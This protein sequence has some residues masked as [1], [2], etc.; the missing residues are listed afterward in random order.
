MQMK[1]I[2]TFFWTCLL[3]FT[4]KAQ[5]PHPAIKQFLIEMKDD[6]I[7]N[8]LKEL[9]GEKTCIVKGQTTTIKNRVSKNGNDLAA[10][11]LKERLESYGLTVTDQKYS[12][13]GR[14]IFAEQKGDMY[15]DK[16]FLICA[17]YDSMADYCADDN[18]SGCSA[19]LE[20]VRVL[21][22]Y[23]FKHTIV[24][25]FWD[26]EEQGLIGSAYYAKQAKSSGMNIMGVLNMDMIGYDGNNDTKFE[27]YTKAGGSLSLSDKLQQ[28][29]TAY[30]FK[31]SPIVKNPGPTDT[32]HASF[33]T[34]GYSAIHF[35][36][37]FSAGD[38]NPAYHKSTDRISLFN[39]P[40]FYQLCRLGLSA[41]ATL[42]EPY[43]VTGIGTEE[44]ADNMKLQAYPNPAR[45][46]LTINY[47]LQETTDLQIRLCNALNSTAE[48]ILHETENAGTHQ[49]IINTDNLASGIYFIVMTGNSKIYT[50][51]IVIEK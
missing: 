25:A 11:Y 9:S 47:E 27:I 48:I 2:Y 29:N 14:N 17:H 38:A 12:T 49:Q 32:D 46:S 31:L 20:S 34:Q 4:V 42:A 43:D 39:L 13:G 10:D 19:I 28:I 33:W 7:L 1:L 44:L 8:Y 50:S 40:Y 51:K 45:E 30:T 35:G 16:K 6:S 36:E 24:Y 22:K 3:C 5:I 15:P 26:E 18:A 41:I 21:S 37:A 23:K